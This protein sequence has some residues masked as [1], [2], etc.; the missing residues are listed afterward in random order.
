MRRLHHYFPANAHGPKG[1]PP[2]ALQEMM[3]YTNNKINQT[4]SEVREPWRV[5]PCPATPGA[6]S[7]PT[8]RSSSSTIPLVPLQADARNVY[9]VFASVTSKVAPP[10]CFGQFLGL[11]C[12]GGAT[13]EAC[14]EVAAKLRALY[15]LDHP[16]TILG[17]MICGLDTI[18]P[19]EVN[20]AYKLSARSAHPDKGGSATR[21][22]ALEMAKCVLLDA[23]WRKAYRRYGWV[24]VHAAWKKAAC[25][26]LSSFYAEAP[27]IQA[28]PDFVG[29]AMYDGRVLVVPA[30]TL[31]LVDNEEDRELF[32]S[33]QWLVLPKRQKLYGAATYVDEFL[34]P[35]V[36]A[37]PAGGA[38][39][40][41]SNA[42]NSGA[43]SVV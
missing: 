7:L 10:G 14:E 13:S 32:E 12:C 8:Y 19:A 16:C 41:D 29:V 28:R 38:D 2:R 40:S 23:R 3:L 43:R 20:R 9:K 36:G 35:P 6:H 31:E 34:Q 27:P 25:G 24:G 5:A 4:M 11:L 30:T 26:P 15:G 37:P 39:P 33:P 18:S 42:E 1:T 22:H 21:M 17:L